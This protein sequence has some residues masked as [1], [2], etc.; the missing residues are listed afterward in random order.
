M[1]QCSEMAEKV[2]AENQAAAA[3]ATN[4]QQQNAQNWMYNYG[5]G[6]GAAGMYNYNPQYAQYYSAYYNHYAQYQQY[7]QQQQQQAQQ[8]VQTNVLQQ[9]QSAVSTSNAPPGFSSSVIPKDAGDDGQQMLKPAFL[10]SPSNPIRFNINS[11]GK[12]VQNPLQ[13]FNNN[14]MFNSNVNNNNQHNPPG[15]G[16]K[17]R[18]KNKNRNNNANNL[19]QNNGNSSSMLMFQSQPLVQPQSQPMIVDEVP[20][21]PPAPIIDTSVPPPPLPNAAKIQTPATFPSPQSSQNPPVSLSSGVSVAKKAKPDPFNNPTDAWPESLNN[22]VTRCY[23]KCKTDF[24]KDQIDICLKGRITAAATKGELWTRDWDNEPIPSVHSER[25]NIQL[26]KMTNNNNTS[27]NSNGS[28]PNG[29]GKGSPKN[30]QKLLPSQLLHKFNS[31]NAKKSNISMHTQS[32]WTK[33]NSLNRSRSRSPQNRKRRSRSRSDS[34]SPRPRK[35]GRRGSSMDS[36]T[37]R[38][39]ERSSQGQ[40]KFGKNNNNNRLN[41]NKGLLTKKNQK[42]QAKK[43]AF[44]RE[45]GM[46]GGDVDGDHERLQQRAARFKG[47]GNTNNGNKNPFNSKKKMTPVTASRLFVDDNAEGNFD[48]IDFHIVG[49]SRDLEKSFLR[50]TKAPAP[51]EVRP[52]EV[53]RNSLQNVKTRWIEKQDY[54]YA[55]D[56]LKSIRQDLTVSLF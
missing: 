38:T 29:K 9:T 14:N 55:C 12:R 2:T 35:G 11:T 15:S 46:I 17:K 10:N 32:N 26:Q 16:K 41:K 18:K 42:M 43:A 47:A 36:R 13:N 34:Q 51:S 5:G 44:Y 56:Q 28:S 6:A 39:S 19:N 48:L 30:N 49:T 8:P 1:T 31:T 53:L 24:D 7:Q 27:P 20:I 3:A 23:A 45:N 33:G 40:I 52:V 21:P 37:S 25:N 4:Q 22:Y 50:L 54:F